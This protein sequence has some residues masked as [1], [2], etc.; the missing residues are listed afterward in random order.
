MNKLILI[1]ILLL[2]TQ[3]YALEDIDKLYQ[4][5]LTELRT[6]FENKLISE[7][8]YLNKEIEILNQYLQAKEPPVIPSEQKIIKDNPTKP[9][10]KSSEKSSP[11]EKSITLTD[12][13]KLNEIDEE[14]GSKIVENYNPKHKSMAWVALSTNRQTLK[15]NNTKYSSDSYFG[16]QLGYH[17]RIFHINSPSKLYYSVGFDSL[18]W[19]ESFNI[20]SSANSL[21]GK[22]KR[23][24]NLITLG[25]SWKMDDTD[26]INGFYLDGG[27]GFY[28]YTTK[29]LI[30]SNSGFPLVDTSEK[31]NLITNDIRATDI[32]DSQKLGF[33][34]GFRYFYKNILLG[35]RYH[36]LKVSDNNTDYD[37]DFYQIF[38]GYVI[39]RWN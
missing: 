26:N 4:N 7:N 21:K 38:S 14:N 9:K 2:T 35:Y 11:E 17:S 32:D 34:A 25:L 33:Y 36:F 31:L 8:S 5:R 18:Q 15:E 20:T 12:K 22:F 39:N 30:T 1:V 27:T 13:Y 37:S 3:I 29:N 16:G 6:L 23:D 24:I 19:E 10:I 28:R